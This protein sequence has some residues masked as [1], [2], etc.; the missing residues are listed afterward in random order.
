MITSNIVSL[1]NEPPTSEIDPLLGGQAEARKVC[2]VFTKI[3]VKTVFIH[4]QNYS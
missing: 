3:F 1:Y 4:S 2:E